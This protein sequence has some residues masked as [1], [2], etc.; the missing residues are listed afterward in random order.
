[1]FRVEA[2]PGS[3]DAYGGGGNYSF[4][5]GK[6]LRVCDWDTYLKFVDLLK[7]QAA[8]VAERTAGSTDPAV[9]WCSEKAGPFIDRYEEIALYLTF[10]GLA[11]HNTEY[12]PMVRDRDCGLKRSPV[13]PVIIPYRELEPF[14]IPGAWR[15]EL[16][17]L[18]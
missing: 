8:L 17:K 3:D 16:L 11:V 9:A 5:F 18:H 2:C 4:Q 12:R 6:L 1:M 13:N 10:R 14:M 15:D 7:T